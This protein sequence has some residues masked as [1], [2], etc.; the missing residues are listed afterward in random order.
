[1]RRPHYLF[2]L[3]VL[4]LNA[5]LYASVAMDRR[6]IRQ[7]AHSIISPDHSTREIVIAVTQFVRNDLHKCDDADVAEMPFWDRCNYLYNRLRPGPR[8][9]LERGTHQLAP[10]QSST[11][12]LKELL[13]A[14]DID[15]QS[16]IMHDKQFQGIHSVAEVDYGGTRGIVDPL[17]GLV[18][19]HADGRPATLQELRVDHNLFLANAARA[20][21][22]GFGKNA[23]SKKV[24]MNAAEYNFERAYYF[25]YGW[26]GPFRLQVYNWIRRL[27]GERGLDV[28]QRPDWYAFPAFSFILCLNAAAAFVAAAWFLMERRGKFSSRQRRRRGELESLS[29]VPVGASGRLAR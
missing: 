4:A 28:L 15:T 26:F 24:T 14:F 1:M 23:H 6:Y 7:V 21:E 16:V 12:V 11:R 29:V 13:E 22:Y 27:W 5:A 3:M 17:Y 2:A 20:W 25:N 18:Y 8:T 9:I 10:C 19:Q